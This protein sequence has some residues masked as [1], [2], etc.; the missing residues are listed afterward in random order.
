MKQVNNYQNNFSC[1]FAESVVDY[2]YGELSAGEMKRLDEHVKECSECSIAY[3]EIADAR[4]AVVNWKEEEFTPLSIPA[5]RYLPDKNIETAGV[6]E[7]FRRIIRALVISPRMAAVGISFAVLFVVAGGILFVARIDSV[8]EIAAVNKATS[9][10][11]LNK[12]KASPSGHAVSGEPENS[13]ISPPSGNSDNSK[14]PEIGNDLAKKPV[15]RDLK[16]PAR[17]LLRVKT[18]IR[19]EKAVTTS[20]RAERELPRLNDFEDYKD[21]TLRLADI[22]DEIDSGK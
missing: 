9:T 6:A 21:N 7:R 20:N 3:A 13:Y 19:S 16:R 8:D 1:S 11:S 15:T 4:Q 5:I 17:K 22:L 10:N 14:S 18:P 2:L 12:E